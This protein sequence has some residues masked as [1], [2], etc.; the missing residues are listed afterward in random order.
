MWYVI[1]EMASINKFKGI[2]KVKM[3]IL[4][5]CL[6]FKTMTKTVTSFDGKKN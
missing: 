3:K 1:E 4:N 2:I 6:K 5:F